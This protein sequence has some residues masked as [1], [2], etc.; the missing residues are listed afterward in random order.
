MVRYLLLT[1]RPP[2]S[3]LGLYPICGRHDLAYS[4]IL[5]LAEAMD[6]DRKTRRCPECRACS[7][8]DR[9]YHDCCLTAYPGKTQTK[10]IVSMY[11]YL[12]V[13]LYMCI[14]SYLSICK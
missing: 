7:H 4:H 6:C 1:E 9:I 3:Y 10:V 11:L 14:V 8:N 12:Y 13:S 2:H 5:D